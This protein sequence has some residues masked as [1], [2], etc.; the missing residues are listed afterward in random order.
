MNKEIIHERDE[1]QICFKPGRKLA[2]PHIEHMNQQTHKIIFRDR[3][4]YNHKGYGGEPTCKNLLE[5]Y[6]CQ[7][8]F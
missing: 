8:K 6:K 7:S 4:S 3:Q 1:G 5:K 2:T